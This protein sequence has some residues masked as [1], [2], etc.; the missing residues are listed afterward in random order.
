MRTEWKVD[1][2]KKKN[3]H[4]EREKTSQK[5]KQ[6]NAINRKWNGDEEEKKTE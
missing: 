6:N 2:D 1:R 4:R 3:T 5:A